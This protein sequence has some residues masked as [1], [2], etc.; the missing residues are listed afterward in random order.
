MDENLDEMRIDYDVVSEFAGH[1]ENR[2]VKMAE[3][4]KDIFDKVKGKAMQAAVRGSFVSFDT[5]DELKQILGTAVREAY[6]IRI[7]DE[8]IGG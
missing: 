2:G 6:S 5:V 7:Y 8:D 3:A 1:K 4:A